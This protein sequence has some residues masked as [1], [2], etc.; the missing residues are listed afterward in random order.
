MSSTTSTPIAPLSIAIIGAGRIGS[1]FAYQLAVSPK[2]IDAVLALR[3]STTRT[4]VTV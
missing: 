2:N 3:P 4:A 1:S